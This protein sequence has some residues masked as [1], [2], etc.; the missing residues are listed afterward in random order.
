MLQIVAIDFSPLKYMILTASQ[1]A[2]LKLWDYNQTTYEV[3]LKYKL[4]NNL[5]SICGAAFL[6]MNC[7]SFCISTV[8]CVEVQVFRLKEDMQKEF[9]GDINSEFEKLFSKEELKHRKPKQ[10][11]KKDFEF[12]T[13]ADI[14]KNM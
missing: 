3:K 1:D 13:D 11:D 2:Y 6:T 14:N 7:S 9:S 5:G 8:D 12:I 10:G 4:N